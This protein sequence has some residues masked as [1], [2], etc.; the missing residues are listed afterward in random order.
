MSWI[1]DERARTSLELLELYGVPDPKGP[2]S[3][4]S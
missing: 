2:M 3:P 4:S 1:Q